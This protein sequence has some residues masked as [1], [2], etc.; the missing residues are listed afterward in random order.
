MQISARFSPEQ[1]RS[2]R[3]AAAAELRR[4]MEKADRAEKARQKTAAVTV[5]KPATD[6]D[7]WRDDFTAFAS[8]LDII[9]KSGQRQ[10]LRPNSIQIAFEVARSG[11]DVILKPRQVGFT[12]WELARDVWFFLTRKGARVVIV[13]QSMA[14]DSAI[15]ELADKLRVM[16]ESLAD[17]GVEIPDLQPSTTHWLIP[18]RDASLKIIGAGASEKSAKK[19]GRSGT[20]HRLHVTELAFFEHADDTL[21]ALEGCVPGREFGTEV[22]LESTANGAQGLFHAKYQAAVRGRGGFKPH[23]FSWLQQSEYRTELEPGERIV[24]ETA[25]EKELVARHGATP[26]QIKWYRQKVEDKGQDLVDQEYPTDPE[27]CWLTSGRPFFDVKRT[28]ELIGESSEPIETREVGRAGSHGTLRIWKR[29]VPGREYALSADPSEGV[30]GDPGAAVVYDRVDGEHVATIHGQFATHEM[31]RVLDEVGREY[32]N[33]LVI[34]ERNNHGHA[35]LQALVETLK[36]PRLFRDKDER[37]G[38]LN[39]GAARPAALEAL[40]DAHREERWSS[41]DRMSLGEMLTFVVGKDGKAE[42]AKGSHDDLVIS[43]AIIWSVLSKPRR[44]YMSATVSSRSEE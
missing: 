22:I 16:F 10:K 9:P 35:V 6:L 27:T 33:A 2:L 3:A 39:N 44:P 42:A 4:R 17:A 18:S 31:A 30:G 40:F 34:V 32:N 25:R 8:L 5:T 21:N 11:R 38:W 23:F 19:K 1:V 14:D 29:P 37:P 26:E 36:Y 41:P 24:P 28:K 20:I 13:T 12:T 15:K 43:H 7:A